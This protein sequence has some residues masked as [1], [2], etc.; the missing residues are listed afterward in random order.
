MKL[1]KIL[2][3]GLFSTALIAQTPEEA[4]DF[5]YDEGGVGIKAQSMGNAF[6]GVADDYSAIYWNPAGLT[7]LESSEIDGGLY[8]LN[9]NNKATFAGSTILDDR[10]FTKLQSLGLAYKFPTTQGS[11]VMA[12]GYNRFKS[13]D[14]YLYFS[15]FSSE[16][17]DLGF[18]LE[19]DAGNIDY[20]PFDGDAQRTEEIHQEGNLSAWSIGGGMQLSP[21]F[22]LG[23][24]LDFYS[25]SS[26]YIMDFYQDDTENNYNQY[27]SDYDAYEL[28]DKILTDFS[29]W[30]LK[31]GSLFH[32]SKALRLGL[33]IDFPRSLV[34]SE[35]FSSRDVIYFDDGYESEAELSSGDWEYIVK[36][37]FKFSGGVAFD[38]GQFTLAGSFEYRDWTQVEFDIPSDYAYT[39]DYESLLDDNR[40][41]AEAFQST[42]G[43]SFG[44]EFRVPGSGIKLR[45][46]YRS[47][48]S[49]LV[50]PDENLDREY[51]S[52][53]LG[54]QVDKNTVLNFSYTRGNWD[55]FSSDNFTPSGTS[56]S[57]KTDRLLAGVTFKF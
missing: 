32:L 14:E 29:G 56:E 1:L 51:L 40:F 25:G 33:T 5:M 24:T 46:G 23:I 34:V 31:I 16:I 57:V 42:L 27:P 13:F 7:Q 4:V 36:Y 55:K 20:Y 39:E 50:S 37:P 47:V 22:A 44:G 35:A 49:P 41:F 54:Y 3:I 53:G 10:N 2:Y 12:F 52:A 45:G 28:H 30:G 17:I 21:R 43:F 18:D 38:L 11:F 8:H 48:P 26:Q 19:D 9:F 15:G 6:T